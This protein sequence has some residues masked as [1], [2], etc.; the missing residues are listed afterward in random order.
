MAP[1]KTWSTDVRD[2]APAH[3]QQEAGAADRAEFTH[4]LVEA[5]TSRHVSAPWC[6]AVRCIAHVGRKTCRA[7]V[8]VAQPE[9]GRVD[10]SCSACGERGVIIGFEGTA[11]DLSSH[12]PRGKKLRVWGFDDKSREVLLAATT[13]IPPL[14]AVVARASPA[15]EIAGLLVLQATLDELDEVYTLVEELT[16]VTRSRRRIELLDDLRAGLC[17]AMDGF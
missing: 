2:L 1:V 6:S 15:A 17:S 16:D 3:G 7:R 8:H 5:A 11:L 10:W 9:A 13:H 12:V 4:R 14:R